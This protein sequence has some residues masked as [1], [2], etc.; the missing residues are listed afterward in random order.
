MALIGHKFDP[1]LSPRN[2]GSRSNHRLSLK[3]IRIGGRGPEVSRL[4]KFI[5]GRRQMRTYDLDFQMCWRGGPLSDFH[6]THASSMKIGLSNF[7]SNTHLLYY[8]I[9]FILFT[10]N[11][12]DYF[13]FHAI[14]FILL[15][16]NDIYFKIIILQLNNQN[17]IIVKKYYTSRLNKVITIEIN[18]RIFVW[19]FKISND[20]I[21]NK[22]EETRTRTMFSRREYIA[23]NTLKEM[24][25]KG[26]KEQES[27]P[28][29]QETAWS[30]CS[31]CLIRLQETASQNTTEQM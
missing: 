23:L 3:L 27:L 9:I 29:G 20:F 28:E 1:R 17:W 8:H 25:M 2:L 12:I 16:H 31:N 6:P 24:I 18:I 30:S 15:P 5:S 13:F 26:P 7:C 14:I 10:F 11:N 19:G 21:D 4:S 22:V